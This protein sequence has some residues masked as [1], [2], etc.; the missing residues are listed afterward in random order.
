MAEF[1]I[2]DA[3]QKLMEHSRQAQVKT[4]ERYEQMSNNMEKFRD[5][6]MKVA[7]DVAVIKTTTKD[8][9]EAVFGNGK[10]GLKTEFTEL[11]VKYQNLEKKLDVDN[12]GE[13]IANAKIAKLGEKVDKI[14]FVFIGITLTA[15]AVFT[16]VINWDK[17]SKFFHI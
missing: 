15:S 1:R 7:V 12:T 10:K 13:I 3:F 2:E 8:V 14:L 11:A 17:I 9:K 6:L 16:V 5:E 4:Q